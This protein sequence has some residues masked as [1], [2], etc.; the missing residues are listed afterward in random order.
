M[1]DPKALYYYWYISPKNRL[2]RKNAHLAKP[3]LSNTDIF[4]GLSTSVTNMTKANDV[5]YY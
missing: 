2:S 4:H 5:A 3:D 1:F